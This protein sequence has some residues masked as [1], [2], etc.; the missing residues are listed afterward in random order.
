MQVVRSLAIYGGRIY[1]GGSFISATAAAANSSG[2]ITVNRIFSW[3]SSPANAG[4]SAVQPLGPTAW[5]GVDGDVYALCVHAGWLV[6]GGSFSGAFSASSVTTRGLAAWKAPIGNGGDKYGIWGW[7]AGGVDGTI[8]ALASL[9]MNGGNSSG[10]ELIV[11]GLFSGIGTGWGWLAVSNI[12][13]YSGDP[14]ADGG[15]GRWTNLAGGLMGGGVYAV[16]SG[17]NPGEFFAGGSFVSPAT[18]SGGSEGCYGRLA[19]WDGSGW[20]AIGGP[21]GDV[22]ALAVYAPAAWAGAGV[23]GAQLFVGGAFTAVDG[24]AAVGLARY[25]GGKWSGI[26]GTGLDGGAVLAMQV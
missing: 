20:E 18:T 24:V 2:A 10:P 25:S 6:V 14:G 5:A 1:V 19:R 9:P 3:V 22:L 15:G 11:A 26:A 23:S 7:A 17:A 13:M 4:A 12:A 21:K 16:V 8:Y